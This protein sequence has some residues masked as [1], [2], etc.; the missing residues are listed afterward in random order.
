M[1]IFTDWVD[2][3]KQRFNSFGGDYITHGGDY[4]IPPYIAMQVPQSFFTSQA[5]TLHSKWIQTQLDLKEVTEPSAKAMFIEELREIYK[6]SHSL[7]TQHGDK[8]PPI[9]KSQL[10]HI[11]SRPLDQHIA[12]IKQ[13]TAHLVPVF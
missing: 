10:G 3:V 12:L 5:A 4:I 7:L 1:A 6:D 13:A 9:P 8:L 2:S 11:I